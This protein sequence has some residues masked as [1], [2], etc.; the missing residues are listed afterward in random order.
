MSQELDDSQADQPADLIATAI[1][2]EREAAWFYEMMAEM[3]T[4]AETRDTLKQLAKDEASHAETLKNLHFEITGH[5][6]KRPAPARAEGNPNLFDF[7]SATPRDALEFALLNETRAA[8]FYQAQADASDDPRIAKT[9]R[10]LAETERDH[11]AYM[12]LQLS[13]LDAAG[14]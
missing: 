4:D 1:Q 13:R 9:F 5:G 6:V 8:D 2:T 3:T 11:A 10:L 12:R 14:G 7:P